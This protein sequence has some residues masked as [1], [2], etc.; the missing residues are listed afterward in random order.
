MD[1]FSLYVVISRVV[2]TVADSQSTIKVVDTLATIKEIMMHFPLEAVE[3]FRI[4]LQ[5]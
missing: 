1:F 5:G 3:L 2:K 4:S